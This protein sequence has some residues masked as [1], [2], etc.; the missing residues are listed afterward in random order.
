MMMNRQQR[1]KWYWQ[2]LQSNQSTSAP[3][4]WRRSLATP[5][6]TNRTNWS[7]KNCLWWPQVLVFDLSSCFLTMTLGF[8]TSALVF[9]PRLLVFFTLALVFWATFVQCP[10]FSLANAQTQQQYILMFW[11]KY[12]YSENHLALLEW[13]RQ[14]KIK[15]SKWIVY[16]KVALQ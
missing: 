6:T 7:Q 11:E 4:C 16:A 15:A 8:L 5:L 3:L 14:V 1:Q 12:K 13:S 9:S 10:H 2:L